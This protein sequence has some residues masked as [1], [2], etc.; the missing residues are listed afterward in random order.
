MKKGILL[1]LVMMTPLFVACGGDG[2]DNEDYGGG[3]SPYSPSSYEKDIENRLFGTSWQLT[4][5]DP[6]PRQSFNAT[7]T[8]S[9][10]L[11]DTGTDGVKYYYLYAIDLD[12][13]GYLTGNFV[14]YWWIKDNLLKTLFPPAVYGISVCAQLTALLGG[15]HE[16][17]TLNSSELIIKDNYDTRYFT[18]TSYKESGSGGNSGGGASSGEAPYVIGYDFI[19]TKTSITYKFDCSERPTSA[20]VKY[21]KTRTSLNSTASVKISDK[22]VTATVSGL[23]SGTEYYFQCTVTNGYGSS[24]SDIVKAV[25]NY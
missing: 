20:T 6:A 22:R 17:L 12:S 10:S 16:V 19:A 4:S 23:S 25:T 13:P 8:F 24:K 15:N 14:G 11:Y 1:L 7:L 3:S 9:S 5:I 21:G 18:R 2:D